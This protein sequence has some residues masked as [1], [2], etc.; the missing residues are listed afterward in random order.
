MTS[1]FRTHDDPPAPPTDSMGCAPSSAYQRFS[2]PPLTLIFALTI[3]PI[4]SPFSYIYLLHS[5]YCYRI[6]VEN[7]TNLATYNPRPQLKT[8]TT[9]PMVQVKGSCNVNWKNYRPEGGAGLTSDLVSAG[10]RLVSYLAMLS[11][12]IDSTSFFPLDIVVSLPC[13]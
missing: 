4:T 6:S 10:G 9:R 8:Q 5:Q 11:P 3:C 13:G 12:A 7:P 2:G 1:P